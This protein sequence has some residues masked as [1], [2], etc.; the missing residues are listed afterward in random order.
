MVCN[1]VR[2]LI[3]DEHIRRIIKLPSQDFTTIEYESGERVRIHK[4]RR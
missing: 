2:Q 4:K 3:P 1:V